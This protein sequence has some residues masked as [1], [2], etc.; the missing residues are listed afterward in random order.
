MITCTFAG[1]REA[2]LPNL[3]KY[4][5]AVIEKILLT[6]SEFL[7]LNG[8]M[9]KFD[10]IC[11]SAVRAAKSR[12]PEIKITLALVMPYFIERLNEDKEYYRISYDKIIIPAELDNA[13]YKAAIGRRNRWM[14]DRADI[15][16]AYVCHDFGGAYQTYRYALRRK[17]E[18]VN[19]A[20]PKAGY[21]NDR[22]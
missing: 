18:T 22:R 19:L 9:G 16:I 2:Y 10:G 6:D 14:V 8:G 13:H 5:E 11:A 20:L 1:H 7:F 3:E 17:K 21:Y 15:L 12:H 4:V